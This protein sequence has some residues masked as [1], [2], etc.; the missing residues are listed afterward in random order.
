MKFRQHF[1]TNQYEIDPEKSIHSPALYAIWSS[2]SWMLKIAADE[3]LYNSTYFFW[4]D[5]GAWR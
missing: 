2:K 5:A 4:V 3:N 1:E